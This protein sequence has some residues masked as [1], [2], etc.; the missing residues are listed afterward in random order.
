MATLDLRVTPRASA[1]R[2]GPLVEGV[3]EVRVA[4][5][6]ADGEA[7]RAVLKLV[8][9]ALGVAPSR[10]VLV[11]GERGRRKRV[12]IDGI[13]AAELERRLSAIGPD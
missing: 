12:R 8:A 2:V 13:E 3:L 11:A 5:P 6:P 1:D 7:N 4:R 9:G 10:L